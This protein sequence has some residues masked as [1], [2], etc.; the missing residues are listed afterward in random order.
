MDHFPR[1]WIISFRATGSFLTELMDHFSRSIQ[2]EKCNNELLSPLD[3]KLAKVCN[4][5]NSY[6]DSNFNYKGRIQFDENIE[7]IKKCIIGHIIA[8][9]DL[10]LNTDISATEK[11]TSLK[12]IFLDYFTGKSDLPSNYRIHYWIHKYDSIMFNPCFGIQ[13]DIRYNNAFITC[14][15][16]KFKP[17][18]FPVVDYKNSI[19][20][21]DLPVLTS[22]NSN[23]FSLQFRKDLFMSEDYPIKPPSRGLVLLSNNNFFCGKTVK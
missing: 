1:W 17:L 7:N 22:V 9:F 5:F 15:L 4:L 10:P 8:G 2:C 16:L 11:N 14:S 21:V 18:G 19:C 3:A 20:N 13:A 6:L 23:N 12:D